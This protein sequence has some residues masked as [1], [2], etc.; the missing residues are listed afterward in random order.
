MQLSKSSNVLI[1]AHRNM[2]FDA[3]GACAAAARLAEFC[4]VRANIIINENDPNM[5]RSYQ[6]LR[7]LEEYRSMFI[8][9]TDALEL[10][11]SET[12]LLI[13]DVNNPTQFEAPDVAERV[14]RTV[15]IDHHRKTAEF[16]QQPVIA[17]IEPSASSAS[18]LMAEI[19]EQVLPA[20]SLAKEE[21]D[22]M[23]AGV[24]LDTKHFTQSVG[25]RTFS[26][27]LYLRSEGANPADAERLFHVDM[28]SFRR[29]ARFQSNVITYR[30]G[31]GIALN[32]YPDNDTTD[33]VAAAKA[34]DKLLKV[35]GMVATFALC[36]IGETVVISARSNGSINVQ[37]IA[38]KLGGGG[39]YDAAAA[40]MK[41]VTVEEALE[42]LKA[43]IDEYLDEILN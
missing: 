18:E 3:L 24:L 30:G 40:Q 17:Y 2:D 19:L 4:G 11:T 21:A 8:S 32:E 42:K 1:M 10:M 16:R 9:G 20:G 39:H 14:F 37:L 15:I 25:T 12:L 29:E 23:F 13:C 41:D 27:S 36:K 6:L 7:K 5:K 22:L 26:A 28:D 34:A 43:A 33:R 31:I 38:E 35:E